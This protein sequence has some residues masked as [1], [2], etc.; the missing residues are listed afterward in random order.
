MADSLRSSFD[1]LP[2]TDLELAIRPEVNATQIV[3]SRE[4]VGGVCINVADGKD[5][6]RL[7]TVHGVDLH[8]IRHFNL[9]TLRA[10]IVR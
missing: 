9:K 7:E 4:I 6:I 10:V 1:E 8:V 3:V 5:P 2:R